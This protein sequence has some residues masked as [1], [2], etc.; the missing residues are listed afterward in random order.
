MEGA[1][2][3][4]DV[5]RHFAREF[6]VHALRREGRDPDGVF[7]SAAALGQA[8]AALPP[9]PDHMFWFEYNFLF[10]LAA[11]GE[12]TRLGDHSP[13]GYAQRARFYAVSDEARLR[14]AKNVAAYILFLAET[15]GLAEE[16]AVAA[17][18]ARLERLATHAA[19]VQDLVEGGR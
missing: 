18:R 11:R 19:F 16:P 1:F 8:L 4:D 2:S 15:T 3:T 14:Y 12:T 10:V 13:E 7:A 9:S 5:R 17:A 6:V